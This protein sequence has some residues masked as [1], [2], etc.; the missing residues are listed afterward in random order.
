M[1]EHH[2]TDRRMSDAFP[3]RT[4]SRRSPPSENGRERD[5]THP[6][7]GVRTVAAYLEYQC[8]MPG[9]RIER[10]GASPHELAAGL[11]ATSATRQSRSANAGDGRDLSS[12]NQSEVSSMRLA[13]EMSSATSGR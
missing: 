10:R 12:V 9:R 8:R 13:A 4:A 3:A 6:S 5:T 2:A 11:Y 1:E 7:I